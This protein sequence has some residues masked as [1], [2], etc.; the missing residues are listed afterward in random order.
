MNY[1]GEK[2]SIFL[3]FSL[4]ETQSGKGFNKMFEVKRF[5][6]LTVS[7]RKLPECFN[8]CGVC[9][10]IRQSWKLYYSVMCLASSWSALVYSQQQSGHWEHTGI[11]L[12]PFQLLEQT[13]FTTSAFGCQEGCDIGFLQGA[14]PLGLILIGN[15]PP[16]FRS[17][18]WEMMTALDV[19]GYLTW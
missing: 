10:A 16:G 19:W 1:R 18:Q 2:S 5:R 7:T 12:L 11:F 3:G 9:N 17:F 4:A 8:M 14:V 15:R 6:F 13:T